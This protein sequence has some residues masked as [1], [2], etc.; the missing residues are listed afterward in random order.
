MRATYRRERHDH[1]GD[2][3][4]PD[5]ARR[6]DDAGELQPDQ[7]EHDRLQDR[8]GRPPHRLLLQAGWRSRSAAPCSRG[9]ARRRPPRARRTCAPSRRRGTIPNGTTSPSA[10]STSESSRRVRILCTSQPIAS[11]IAV[12]PTAASRNMPNPSRIEIPA[13]AA[14]AT[15]TRNSVSA[16]AS[17]TR[18]S[19]PMIVMS[20]RGRP[21]R[22]PMDSA[23]TASGGATTA[24]STSAAGRLRPGHHPPGHQPDRER[25]EHRQTRPR[26]ARSAAGSAGCPGT[27]TPAPTSTAAA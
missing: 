20:R 21:S 3:Q 4:R 7:R 15:N 11:P 5:V 8:V 16:V 1:P 9:R 19:P 17:L 10:L 2:Q 18:L 13:P 6:R 23:D 24:P 26:A 25:A 14:T 27:T 22:R 12:P